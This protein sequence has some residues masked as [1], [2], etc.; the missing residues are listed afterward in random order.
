VNADGG[1][2]GAGGSGGNGG[3][4]G[5]GGIGSPAGR[6]GLD[7]H[8]GFDGHAGSDGAAGMII[9]SVDPAAQPFLGNL[10]L[11]NKSGGRPGPA[12]EIRVEPVPPIW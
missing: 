11:S 4:G 6:S 12:P 5:S 1:P 2:G 3:R 9:V 10:R 7:G 8:N